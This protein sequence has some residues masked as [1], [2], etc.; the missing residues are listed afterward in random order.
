MFLYFQLQLDVI[1]IP[2]S[3]NKQRMKENMDIFDFELN[4]EEVAY[5]ETFETG[6]RTHPR[7]YNEV[8]TFN[9]KYFPCNIE[10]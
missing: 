2:K 1:L 5:M 3:S 6:Q 8:K 4:N 9:H 10:F 7:N